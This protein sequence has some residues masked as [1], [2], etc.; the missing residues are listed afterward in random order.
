MNGF[1][2]HGL[3]LTGL[4]AIISLLLLASVTCK[5]EENLTQPKVETISVTQITA[6]SAK[7]TT[8]VTDEGGSTVGGT[9]VCWGN[10]INPDLSNN[11]SNAGGGI[12]EFITILTSLH[13]NTLYHVRAF[14]TNAVGT[15]YG[16]NLTFT[17]TN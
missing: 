2:K 3:Q 5:K 17:T 11:V 6:T 15:A 14:A 10:S 1:K 13:P 4:I 16:N 8:K 12:G 9:G 7:V